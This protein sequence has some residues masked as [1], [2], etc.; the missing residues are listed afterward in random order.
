V[1]KL[2]FIL[3]SLTASLLSFAQETAQDDFDPKKE[4]VHDGKRYRVWNNYLTF[5]GMPGASINSNIPTSQSAAALDLNFHIKKEYF[6]TG[7]LMSG[8]TFGDYN[9]SQIHFCWGKRIERT[10]YNF[11]AFGG[12]DY[13]LFYLWA[14][15]SV[16]ARFIT[17]ARTAIGAYAAIQNYWKFKYDVGIGATVFASYNTYRYLYGLRIELFFSSAYRGDKGRKRQ[18]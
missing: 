10:R 16:P 14:K 1:K 12:V 5:G 8:N 3:F 18:N 4:I 15:D 2:L 11:A 7:I 9:N 17:P 13:S 6:Q